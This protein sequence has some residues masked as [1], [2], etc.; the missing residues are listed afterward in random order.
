MSRCSVT[1]PTNL[2]SGRI[3]NREREG[4]SRREGHGEDLRGSQSET[5]C[6]ILRTLE[7]NLLEGRR[8]SHFSSQGS[9]HPYLWPLLRFRYASPSISPTHISMHT[10]MYLCVKYACPSC[11]FFV[12]LRSSCEFLS[13]LHF[14]GRSCIRRKLH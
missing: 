6:R 2:R 1:K 10:Y 12:S 13:Y 7:W 8:Q 3:R 4:E 11:L 5:S 9:R 14:F